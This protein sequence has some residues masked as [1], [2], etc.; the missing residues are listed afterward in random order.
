MKHWLLAGTIAL[1]LVGCANSPERKQLS[2]LEGLQKALPG[3]YTSPAA[4]GAADTGVSL[5]I[6]PVT[7]QLIGEKVYFVRETPA[8]NAGLVLWQGIWTFVAVAPEGHRHAH[9]QPGIMQHSFLFKE[10]RRWA[11][12]SSN[13]DLLVSMLPDDLQ[14]LPGCDL[15]W[16]STQSTP[17]G[18]E[19][20]K[21]TGDCRPGRL[22]SG[23]WIEQ[24]AQLEGSML[25]LI[26]QPLD[27]NGAPDL[28]A[29]AVT[30]HLTRTGSPP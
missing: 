12:A 23:L 29:A 28:R 1:M 30:R 13:P 20:K 14:P 15:L 18:Y 11:A 16:Q 21:M 7:A 22:A 10:P 27:A 3:V 24:H 5:T 8:D 6:S 19:T 17:M 9:E 2:Q 26:E 25:T 4:S